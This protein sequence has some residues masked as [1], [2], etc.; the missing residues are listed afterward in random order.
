[1][2]VFLPIFFACRTCGLAVRGHVLKVVMYLGILCA[3]TANPAFSAVITVA[4]TSDPWLA[5]MTNGATA[6]GG[7]VAPTQSPAEV[8]G[9]A[10]VPGDG[11]IF[12]ASGTEANVTNRT[13][14]GPEGNTNHVLAHSAGAQNGISTCNAPIDSLLGVFLGPDLPSL[15]PAPANLDFGTQAARDY[16]NLSPDLKQVFFIGDCVT[17]S[18]LAQTVVVPAGATRLFLGPMDGFHWYDNVGAF[19]VIVTSV[20]RLDIR[21]A[22]LWHAGISWPTN[23]PDYLLEYSTNMPASEWIPITNSSIVVGDKFLVTVDVAFRQQ[24]FRL[25]RP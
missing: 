14:F 24:F 2:R 21:P 9:L 18:G 8:V 3:V 15:Y 6:S 13:A 4:G 25:R 11:L 23:A 1:M 7:D 22:D 12:A 17:S 5:G 20:P 19:T 16:T 10:I